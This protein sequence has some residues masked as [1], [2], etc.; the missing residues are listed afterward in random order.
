MPVDTLGILREI[1]GPAYD[2]HYDIYQRSAAH[3]KEHGDECDVYPST[4][5]HSLWPLLTAMV[6]A[7]RFLEVGC[8]LGY[9]AAMMAEAGGRR[10]RSTRSSSRRFTPNWHKKRFP[11]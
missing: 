7:K 3:R 9:T 1:Y 10:R 5:I 11:R 6:H 2:L 8:G 4:A